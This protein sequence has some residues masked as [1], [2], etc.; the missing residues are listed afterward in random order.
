MS[1]IRNIR[2]MDYAEL[3]WTLHND[4]T[5]QCILGGNEI[6]PVKFYDKKHYIKILISSIIK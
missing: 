6:N 2:A 5:V 3:E 1:V 4:K